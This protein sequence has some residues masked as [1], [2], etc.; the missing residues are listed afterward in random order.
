MRN[1]LFITFKQSK[2]EPETVY[3][4]GA[5][6]KEYRPPGCEIHSQNGAA[7]IDAIG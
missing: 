2:S 7:T 5:I 4:S 1:H 3:L 6:V